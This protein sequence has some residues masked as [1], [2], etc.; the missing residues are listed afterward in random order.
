MSHGVLQT[1]RPEA[2]GAQLLSLITV[3]GEGSVK[4]AGYAKL[5]RAG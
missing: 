3:D 4:T 5:R 2:G 1:Q